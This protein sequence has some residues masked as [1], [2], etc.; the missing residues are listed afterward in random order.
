MEKEFQHTKKP[1]SSLFLGSTNDVL[2]EFHGEWI[3]V[4]QIR[5]DSNTKFV[6]EI[7]RE[8]NISVP[9][10]FTPDFRK[11]LLIEEPEDTEIN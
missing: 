2:L 7:K 5:N 1:G 3:S 9:I 8:N 10:Y 11:F 6:Q 4:Y